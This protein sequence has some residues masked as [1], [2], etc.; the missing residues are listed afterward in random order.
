MNALVAYSTLITAVRPRGIPPLPRGRRH[1]D[2]A[3]R[4]AQAADTAVGPAEDH[5]A[6]G[7]RLALLAKTLVWKCFEGL[8][9]L[10]GLVLAL[11]RLSPHGC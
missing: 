2:V 3:L 7:L 10:E 5:D 11:D 6:S 9:G 8:E 4:A 1:D